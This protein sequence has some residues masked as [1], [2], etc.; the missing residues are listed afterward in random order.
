MK[1]MKSMKSIYVSMYLC[2]YEIYEIYLC[3][4]VSMYL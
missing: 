4:Y 3:I 2:I 1:P